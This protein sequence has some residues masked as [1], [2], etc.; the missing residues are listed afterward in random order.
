MEKKKQIDCFLPYSTAAIT[1]SLAAQLHGSGVVKSIYTL[2]ADVPPTETLPQYTH[3]LQAGSLLSLA[4][5]RLIAATATADYALF[6]LKQGPITLGYH[7]LERMLQVAEETEAAMVYADHYSVEAGKTVKHPVT[8]YQLGSI[9]DDFD[10]G[11]V[12]LLKTDY[13]KGFEAKK[14]IARDYQYAGWYALRLFLSRK[15]ELF[16]LN[17]YLYTEEEDDLRASGEKQFDYVN[18]RNREVQIEMEQ[19]AT[20]HLSTINALV[21]TTQYA[22]PDFSAEAFPV[23]ASVVIPVFNREKTVRDAVVSALSQKTDFPFNVI[24]CRQS[25][26]R[27]YDGDS[28]FFGC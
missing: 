21:D 7:A 28:L 1:Q 18:P 23:E 17:E 20:A 4:T 19:A 27:S 15:G 3:H 25:F 22:Q 6:Y 12:V 14:E 26:D 24:R 8:D 11:S 2:A 10:F 9:R 13:L 5:M 16:H